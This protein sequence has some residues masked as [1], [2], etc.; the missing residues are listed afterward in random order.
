MWR[1]ILRALGG[2]LNLQ[3]NSD[4]PPRFGGM[5]AAFILGWLLPP[6]I[7][8]RLLFPIVLFILPVLFVIALVPA[9]LT[10]LHDLRG[11]LGARL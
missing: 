1:T 4:M 6:Q 8:R 5:V 7:L 2:M 11:G 10:V 9:V 3:R